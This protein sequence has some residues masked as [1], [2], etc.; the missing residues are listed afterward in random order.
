MVITRD[1]KTLKKLLLDQIDGSSHLYAVVEHLAD[2][3]LQ[4]EETNPQIAAA[5]IA[6]AEQVMQN[7]QKIHKSAKQVSEVVLEAA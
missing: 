7:A 3:A 2:L 6:Q 4:L 1:A 5:I